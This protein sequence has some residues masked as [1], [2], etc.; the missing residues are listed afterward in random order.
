MTGISHYLIT[1]IEVL[2]ISSAVSYAAAPLSIRL[3][4]KLG[5]IDKPKDARR[6]HKKPI[7]RFGGMS[8]FL[9]SMIA[10]LIPAGMNSNIKVAMLG[11]LLMYLLGIADDIKDLKPIVKFGGQLVIA[12]IVY[13]LG[14]RITFIGNYFGAA[15]TDAHANV[16]LSGG[17]AYIITVFWIVGITN[18]VNLMDG[19]DGLAADRKSVV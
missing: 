7:P 1:I 4:H 18:A 12:T 2:A 5:V 8:I 17:L 10:M 11:G 6:V 16:I 13:A 15:V 9:G 19:L 3:A 14:I